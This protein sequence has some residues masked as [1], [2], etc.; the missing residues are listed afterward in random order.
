MGL[1]GGVRAG[2]GIY[3]FVLVVSVKWREG[4]IEER[5]VQLNS[6][7]ATV[8]RRGPERKCRATAAKKAKARKGCSDFPSLSSQPSRD[9]FRFF[10]SAFEFNAEA[11]R[12][13][14]GG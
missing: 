2:W 11:R 7:V 8:L 3:D 4:V 13:R 10:V 1:R 6:A 12:T 5:E 14:R 9:I